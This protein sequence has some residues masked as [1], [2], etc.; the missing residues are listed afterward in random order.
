MLKFSP[1]TIGVDE[2][3]R[4][5]LAGP[6][7]VCACL[8]FQPIE[9]L[10]DSKKLTEKKRMELMPLILR[11]SVSEIAIASSES[12]DESDILSCTL[13][14]MERAI[15]NLTCRTDRFEQ[16]LVDGNFT[17]KSYKNIAESVVKGDSLYQSIAA[18]SIVAKVTRD[19][20]MTLYDSLYPEYG[21]KENKG[22]GTSYHTE[23]IK[24]VG[25]SEIHRRSFRLHGDNKQK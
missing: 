15:R 18:A 10:N 2:A 12:I 11:N 4:G 5:P 23:A 25:L 9:G 20:I 21:F 22:Y 24:R 3:G 17:P 14:C 19:Y 16:I 13:S 6:V 1:G 8:L 7:V